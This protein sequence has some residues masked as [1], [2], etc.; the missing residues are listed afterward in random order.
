MRRQRNRNFRHSVVTICVALVAAVGCVAVIATLPDEKRRKVTVSEAASINPL[1]TTIGFADSEIYLMS[2]NDVSTTVDK[3]GLTNTGTVRIGIPWADVEPTQNQLNW[4]NA[5]MLINTAAAKN[6]SII[7]VLTTSPRWAMASGALPPNGRPANPAQYGDFTAKVA[8]RYKGKIAAYEI[9]NEPNGF[10]GYSPSP[11][12][13]GYTDLLKAAYPKIKAVDSTVT[14]IGGVLG[15]G[16]TWGSLTINPVDFLNQMYAAGAK[17]FFDALSFHPYHFT[18]KFS[19]GMTQADTPVDQLVRMRK[20]M[21]ANSDGGKKIWATEYG[22]PTSQINE[23]GQAAFIKDILV[24][25]QELPYAGPLMIYTTR[26]R[27]TGGTANEDTY[28]VYRTDWTPKPAQQVMQAPPSVSAEFNRF[29]AQTDPSLGE[30]LSPVYRATPTVWA[31]VR[32]SGMIWET[33]AQGQFISSPGP[34]G[35]LARTRKV[36]PTIPFANGYQDFTGSTP[37]R[38]WYS[39]PT[40]AHWASGG[41][42]KAWVPQLGLAT[43]DEARQSDGSSKVDFEH[44]RITWR[45]FAGAKVE[46]F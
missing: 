41:I 12:A 8:S 29:S 20:L 10:R 38:I 26:D 30:V 6:L 39:Q 3:W 32:S 37:I 40:G 1:P 31:Q 33:P 9:W 28:G 13:V 36:I 44:G 17:G 19:D 7:C 11:N 25:W 45:P 22:Q 24:K 43:T 16:K 35:D 46:Y 23:A 18:V 42:Y 21:T 2:Q 5:D 27:R 15:S 34:V 4:T 14:V